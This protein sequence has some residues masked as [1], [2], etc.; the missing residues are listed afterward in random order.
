MVKDLPS[1]YKALGLTPS[2]EKRKR[3][4]SKPILLFIS[5]KSFSVFNF[6]LWEAATRRKDL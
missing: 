2:I 5:N 1:I 6:L 3:N 4:Q